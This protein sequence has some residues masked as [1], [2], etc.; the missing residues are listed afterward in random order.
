MHTTSACPVGQWSVCIGSTSA[1][2][3]DRSGQQ[4][5]VDVCAG[6]KSLSLGKTT[7]Y[8]LLSRLLEE[9]RVARG[10]GTHMRRLNALAKPDLQPYERIIH[11]S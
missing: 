6:A 10:E 1:H 7:Y 9:L 4:D 5:L 8:T 2:A 3:L 11:D